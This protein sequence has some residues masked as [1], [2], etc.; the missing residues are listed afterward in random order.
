MDVANI[1]LHTFTVSCV[2]NEKNQ[3]FSWKLLVVYGPAYEDRKVEF[4]DELHSIISTWQGPILI[5][6]YF[7]LCRI[8]SDKNN[9]RIN[10]KFAN[11]FND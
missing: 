8:A 2:L 11:C 4:I 6:G 3:N 7:N 1:K 5:G 10:Q 9:G